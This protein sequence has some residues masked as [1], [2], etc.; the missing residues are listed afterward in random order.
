MSTV[1]PVSSPPPVPR[2]WVSVNSETEGPHSQA[3]IAACLSA[4]QIPA[5]ALLCLEGDQRWQPVS[6]WQQFASY[7]GPAALQA[8]LAEPLLPPM[9]THNPATGTPLI[10]VQTPRSKTMARLPDN[11]Q[12]AA[13]YAKYVSPVLFVVFA[14]SCVALAPFSYT[15]SIS[16]AFLVDAVLLVL[17]L[18]A[19]LLLFVGAI[20]LPGSRRE[21][22]GTMLL[23]GWMILGSAVL[24]IL[25]GF[26]SLPGSQ[27]ADVEVPDI[28]LGLVC[29][30]LPVLLVELGYVI[31]MLFVLHGFRERLARR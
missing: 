25:S 2:W 15:N 10:Q 29:V 11:V 24:Q 31:F 26:A 3:Y 30:M 19:R 17:D 8:T 20:M 14:F 23:G 6:S 13:I 5:T 16:L 27:T 9:P 7:V 22:S 18:A 21:G 28:F 12:L 1:P 4:G